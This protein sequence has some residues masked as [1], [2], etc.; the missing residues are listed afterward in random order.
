[1]FSLPYWVRWPSSINTKIFSLSLQ[2]SC[3]TAASNLLTKAVITVFPSSF[4]SSINPLPVL[5]RW[6][7]ICVWMK[8]SRICLSRLMRSVTITKRGRL[9]LLPGFMLSRR[10][11]LVSMIMV[12]VLPLPWVCQTTPFRVSAPSWSRIRFMHFLTAKYCL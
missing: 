2:Y 10:I 8:L 5:A 1:M 3:F 6:G 12:M 9:M 11:I 7:L 4:S